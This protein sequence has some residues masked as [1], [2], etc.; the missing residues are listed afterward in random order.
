MKPGDPAWD[1]LV[2]AE[3]RVLVASVLRV[4]GAARLDLAE[5]VAQEA[6]LAAL[7]TWPYHGMPEQPG[8][9]LRRVARNKALDRLRHEWHVQAH[10]EQAPTLVAELEDAP[11]VADEEL[12]L[13]L[14]C[15][16]PALPSWDR[17]LLALNLACGFSA[18][19]IGRVSFTA[20]ASVAQRLVRAKRA[21]RS[22][23]P[24]LDW[25]DASALKA[26]RDTAMQAIYL[27]FSIGYAPGEGLEAA[28][29]EV[30]D[31]ALRL[32]ELLATQPATRHPDAAALAAL[33]CFQHARTAARSD[34]EGRLVLL[35]E[36]DRRR[37][38][39]VRIARGQHWLRRAMASPVLTPI[40]LEAGIASAHA[41]AADGAST[42]WP[43]IRH[44]YDQLLA[45]TASPV[46]A[47]N[48]AV[49]TL[50]CGD[51]AAALDQ[52]DQIG[53][54]EL[55]RYAPLHAA[56]AAALDALGR[57]D[58]A[59]AARQRA[60]ACPLAAP[61]QRHLLNGLAR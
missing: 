56:R 43:A 32:A 16:Q 35:P 15:A 47:I 55:A 45:M 5:D 18:R 20:E 38:D 31:E 49:A 7:A 60:L 21:L 42:D 57:R 23:A 26:R 19:Q 61:E 17:V 30:L 29:V 28:C 4:V 22:A 2:R 41:A 10:A 12:R 37:W 54:S 52:L 48:R 8:A 59:D 11:P 50:Q 58:E 6:L 36:Q 40:H 24:A 3:R 13:L 1:A 9:W 14:L 46:V 27:M 51:A 33:L 34:A 53:G 25:P 44:W 39:A